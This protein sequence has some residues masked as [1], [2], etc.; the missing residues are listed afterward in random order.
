[1]R[2]RTK[3][4]ITRKVIKELKQLSNINFGFEKA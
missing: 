3:A 1:M 4:I 2:N